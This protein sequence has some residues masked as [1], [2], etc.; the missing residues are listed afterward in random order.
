LLARCDHFGRGVQLDYAKY[1]CK[2]SARLA[3]YRELMKLPEATADDFIKLGVKPSPL[4]GEM[5]EMSHKLHLK[6]IPCKTAIS[7][8]RNQFAKRIRMQNNEA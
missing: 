4:L 3:E 2:L 7:Q 5:L 8:T 1:E 6:G